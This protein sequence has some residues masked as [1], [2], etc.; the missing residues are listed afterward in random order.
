MLIFSLPPIHI[1]VWLS[2]NLWLKPLHFHLLTLA[3]QEPLEL[4]WLLTWLLQLNSTYGVES[5]EQFFRISPKAQLFGV[6]NH[7]SAI[8]WH[9]M[10]LWPFTLIIL[11]RF[12]LVVLVALGWPFTPLSLDLHPLQTTKL[13][14]NSSHSA[15]LFS[16]SG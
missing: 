4:T 12:N 14:A 11:P 15:L 6:L 10:W 1:Y 5:I 3:K 16:G 13:T 2:K 8:T 9:N 7:R